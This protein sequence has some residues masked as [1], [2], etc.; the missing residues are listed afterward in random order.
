[1]EFSPA[2]TIII[3]TLQVYK[4]EFFKNKIYFVLRTGCNSFYGL[5]NDLW[6]TKQVFFSISRFFISLSGLFQVVFSNFVHKSVPRQHTLCGSSVIHS[7]SRK[8][9]KKTKKNSLYVEFLLLKIIFNILLWLFFFLFFYEPN[10]K[11]NTH[12]YYYV[13]DELLI[14]TF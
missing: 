13:M 8:K 4:E 9:N 3:I 11:Y 5:R 10:N 1:M 6:P 14:T 2:T 7:K 12:A